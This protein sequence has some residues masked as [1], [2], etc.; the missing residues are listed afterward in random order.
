MCFSGVAEVSIYLTNSEQGKGLGKVLLQKLIIESEEN[1]FWM[2][3]SGIFP[4]NIA[5]LK[6][7]ESFRIP[8][9]WSSRKN[10]ANERGLARCHLMERRSKTIYISHKKS[11]KLNIRIFAKNLDY[12]FKSRTV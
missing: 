1:G 11:V 8:N 5:S 2:L 12:A 7:H 3:Q 6:V 4:E 9:C 10:R